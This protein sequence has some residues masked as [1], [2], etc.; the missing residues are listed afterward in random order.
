M[1]KA[2]DDGTKTPI[3]LSS[4][5]PPTLRAGARS[6]AWVL[7]VLEDLIAYCERRNLVGVRE[8]LED[9]HLCALDEIPN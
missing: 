8:A 5:R 4:R 9:V 6:D 1:T 7:G 2:I 3:Y